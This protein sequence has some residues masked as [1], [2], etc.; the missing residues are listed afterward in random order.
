MAFHPRKKFMVTIPLIDNPN[1]VTA[2]WLTKVLNN[3]G[4]SGSIASFTK[5][6]V[7][8]GQVGQNVRFTLTFDGDRSA[9]D[10]IVG[11]FPSSDPE[12]RAAGV[13]QLTYMREA[14]FYKHILPSVKIQT[15]TPLFVD[16]NEETHAFVL[17]MEDLAPAVQ[18]DQI[19]GK[20]SKPG[21]PGRNLDWS[22][23]QTPL[24][25]RS[26]GQRCGYH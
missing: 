19:T 4:Y 14:K 25:S 12:S 20:V 9:P 10:T 24:G 1:D 2:D 3:A 17:V 18:G 13:S 16:F 7:G 5:K 6:N 22:W 8:T 26:A 15:P 11:K 21:Q 23:A